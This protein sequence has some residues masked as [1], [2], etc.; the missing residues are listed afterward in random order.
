LLEIEDSRKTKFTRETKFPRLAQLSEAE[1]FQVRFAKE[2][3]KL[4]KNFVYSLQNNVGTKWAIYNV[5]TKWARTKRSKNNVGTKWA[6]KLLW[7]TPSKN[8]PTKGKAFS[9][10]L[11][12][13]AKQ[14]RVNLRVVI[15]VRV[16][17]SWLLSKITWNLRFQAKAT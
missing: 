14:R 2:V 1:K 9:K 11:T 8:E 10:I 7:K 6:M 3:A 12:N 16:V 5:G 4:Q 13:K 17:C 15:S